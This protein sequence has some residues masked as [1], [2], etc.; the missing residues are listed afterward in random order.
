MYC[1][2]SQMQTIPKKD[3]QTVGTANQKHYTVFHKSAWL[4]E[5]KTTLSKFILFLD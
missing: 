1:N 5:F 4:N 2:F 3:N